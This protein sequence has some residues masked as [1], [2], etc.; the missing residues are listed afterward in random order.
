[1]M[2]VKQE[3][4][5]MY[6]FIFVCSIEL[7]VFFG[8]VS[9]FVSLSFGGETLRELEQCLIECCAWRVVK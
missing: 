2:A 4:L 5:S 8:L 3:H 1:M 7:C 9:M 6:E